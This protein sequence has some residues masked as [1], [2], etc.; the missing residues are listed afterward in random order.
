MVSTAAGIPG[1]ISD[2]V[3]GKVQP[4]QESQA[5]ENLGKTVA[6]T[7][8]AVVDAGARV[9]RRIPTSAEGLQATANKL[10]AIKTNPNAVRAGAAVAAAPVGAALGGPVGAA[11]AAPVGAVVGP[12]IVN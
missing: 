7:A 8:A 10:R 4:G 1:Q 12:R 6:P 11:I 5:A 9:A 3:N 2:I